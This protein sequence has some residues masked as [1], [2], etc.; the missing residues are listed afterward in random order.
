MNE[1]IRY[2][3]LSEIIP[4]EIHPH[5]ETNNDNLQNMINSIKKYGIITPLLVRPKGNVY[6]IVLG[7]RRYKA[8]Q[9]L[10]LKQ[11]PVVIKEL[12]DKQALELVISDNIQRK[13]LT[14]K[15]E[16]LL[17]NQ[18]LSNNNEKVEKISNDLGIPLDR[19]ISKLNT[20]NKKEEKNIVDSKQNNNEIVT[21]SNS[22]NNDIINLSELNKEEL[23][24][25]DNFMNNNEM[26]NN[27]INQNNMLGQENLSSQNTS[28]PTFGGKFFPSLE[29][30]PTNMN[31]NTNILNDTN[32]TSAPVNSEPNI[33]NGT[34]L[35]DLT[36][37]SGISQSIN[38]ELNQQPADTIATPNFDINQSLNNEILNTPSEAPNPNNNISD[39]LQS[40]PTLDQNTP[41]QEAPI[42]DLNVPN[43]LN[44]QIDNN[45]ITL[46]SS[47]T[48]P[49][50]ELP[51]EE[52]KLDSLNLNQPTNI[53][54]SM[55]LNS[56][57]PL[58]NLENSQ[59][60][61]V[62]NISLDLNNQ[63]NLDSLPNLNIEAPIVDNQAIMSMPETTNSIDIQQGQ[64]TSIPQ[65]EKN[66]MPVVNMIKN[67]AI[68]FESL[69][70]NIKIEESDELN[71]YKI[72]IEVEK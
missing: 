32:T 19:I 66:I 55:E 36:D 28:E 48:P 4:G 42:I 10:Q 2:L 53:D 51:Q 68:G 26:L 69:G 13:E 37:L 58:P 62:S 44:Q 9:E 47:L 67:L 16:A 17:Y 54:S 46:N 52:T 50:S 49:T 33:N 29:D 71:S 15:E 61:Q 65:E 56:Q 23:E 57:T 34:N 21:S 12:D 27:Q 31:I 3:Q 70:Y 8:A 41:P 20:L 40:V 5:L 11:V 38:N 22:I 35:I 30:Q 25:E 45:N 43:N 14:T 24:R 6:E 63:P 7:N 64:P 72:Q 18:V 59:Q 60:E 39:I 1:E